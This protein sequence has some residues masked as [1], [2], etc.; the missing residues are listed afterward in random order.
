M[1][2]KVETKDIVKEYDVENGFQAV[3]AF[4]RDIYFKK[5]RLNELGLLGVWLRSD[6][7]RIPFRIPPALYII[8]LIDLDTLRVN[9]QQIGD[10]SEDEILDMVRKDAWMTEQVRFTG[11]A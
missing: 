9:L 8:G 5:I 7:E 11:G 10:F 4:F 3:K 1:R 6:G 2:T